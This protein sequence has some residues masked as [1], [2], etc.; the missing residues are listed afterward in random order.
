MGLYKN[1]NGTLELI[2]GATLFADS[3]IGAIIPY[4]GSSAPAGWF[5]CDGSAISRTTYAELF[6]VIGTS[7]GS[8]DGSTTFNIPDMRESVPKGAGLTGKTV[9][10]HL[11]ADGLAVG[12]F[13]DDRLQEHTH[14]A[15]ITPAG[16]SGS[17]MNVPGYTSNWST[18]G[19]ISARAGATTEVKSVGT[20]YIIKAKQVAIPADFVEAAA[21]AGEAAA[22]EV[23][24]TKVTKFSGTDSGNTYVTVDQLA[25]DQ[26]NKTLGLKVNGADTV[27]P[28]SRANN[29]STDARDRKPIM[30]AMDSYRMAAFDNQTGNMSVDQNY[31]EVINKQVSSGT[32]RVISLQIKAKKS[33][34]LRLYGGYYNGTFGFE[35][36]FT[37]TSQ[38]TAINRTFNIVEGNTYTWNNYRTNDVENASACCYGVVESE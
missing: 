1:N 31:F 25:Y 33:F 38:I 13:L 32:Y 30:F 37:T 35:P 8:G 23:L 15:L 34:T 16:A 5:L 27:I 11:D 7:F 3:P 20:N 19:V 26:T 24:D 29:F 2:S 14:N 10:A 28:F 4:G 36:L 18:S 22:E 6:A 21:D 9:G 17:N 12:E